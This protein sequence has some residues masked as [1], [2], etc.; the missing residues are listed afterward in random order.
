MAGFSMNALR[1]RISFVDRGAEKEASRR[2]RSRS[3]DGKVCFQILKFFRKNLHV[4][5]GERTGISRPLLPDS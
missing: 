5:I 3:G 1:F 4:F 2:F